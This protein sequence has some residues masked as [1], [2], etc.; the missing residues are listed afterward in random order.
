M[1]NEIGLASPVSAFLQGRQASQQNQLGQMR[2]Q[3]A[4]DAQ[5]R[6][7][8]F[9][10]ALPAY[11]TGG[12]NALAALY[13]ADPERAMQA[14]Q[15]TTQQ[16]QIANQQRVAEATT[17][18]RQ[19]SA[20]L[21]S[22][23]PANHMRVL[24]PKQAQ[25]WAQEHG[26]SVDEM[27]DEDARGLADEVATIAGPVAGIGFKE[28]EPF[29]LTEGQTR[30]DSKGKPVASVAKGSQE[31]FTLGDGQTRFDASGKPIASVAKAPPAPTADDVDRPFKRANVLRD[32]YNLQSK[33]YQVVT[34]AY[35]K[36][37]DASANPSPAGDMSLIFGYMKLLDPGSTVREGE[38]A[39]AAEAGSVPTRIRQQYNK[40][41]NGEGLVAE[42]RADFVKQAGTLFQGQQKLNTKLRDKYSTLAD[43]ADVNPKDVLGD[44]IS[45]DVPVGALGVGQSTTTNGFKVTRK[46]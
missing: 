17:A 29:T 36:I 3:Q 24:L 26:K 21:T 1:A 35:Q 9:R 15:F 38:Y 19:A 45:I 30:F 46:K 23:S 8:K 34:S 16:N 40:A 37:L 31:A 41:L 4:Q 18:Y 5:G 43:R 32:E 7:A 39:N 13:A 25:Q 27:T 10:E 44:Q 2:I 22:K 11:L 20:V 12:T 6:D 14:Q 28:Q 33:D 42:M